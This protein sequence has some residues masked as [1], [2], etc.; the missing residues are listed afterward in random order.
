MSYKRRLD[1]SV[2][3]ANHPLFAHLDALDEIK[4]EH[5]MEH[6]GEIDEFMTSYE[7]LLP[8]QNECSIDGVLEK[9]KYMVDAFKLVC[10]LITMYVHIDSSGFYIEPPFA[11]KTVGSEY[12]YKNLTKIG[13]DNHVWYLLKFE[14]NEGDMDKMVYNKTIFPERQ[15]YLQYKRNVKIST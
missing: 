5:V 1:G 11:E 14:W 4:K 10:P 3:V 7:M 15:F 13:V 12:Y 6:L 9:Y 8:V 2:I